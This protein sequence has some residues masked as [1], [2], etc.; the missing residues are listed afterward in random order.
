VVLAVQL[1][2]P[3][4]THAEGPVFC[5]DWGGL[6]WVDMLAGDILHLDAKTGAVERWSVGRVAAAFRPR[7]TGGMIIATER[8]FVVGDFGGPVRSVGVAFTDPA[9]RFNDG[10]CDPAGR[11][12]CG[13]MAYAG[14]PGAGSL[15]RLAG[16]DI[17][18]VIDKV[19]ISNGLEWT[20]DA[21]RVFY[22]DTPTGRVDQFDSDVGG[23]L[24]QRRPFVTIDPAAGSP[25][26][27]A[28]DSQ[29]GV[30]VA[31][32]NGGAVHHYSSSGTLEDVVEL[33]VPKVTACTFGGKNLDQLFITTSRDGENPAA[34]AVFT[35]APGVVGLPVRPFSG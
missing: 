8:E 15:Y 17:E 26:G 28:V 21:E 14:T 24:S 25:D 31:L 23:G 5:A 19:T 20:A 3:E 11:F 22:V 18:T 2:A 29:G 13:T 30:W 6:R 7:T 27:L 32:W 34:G 16:E 1:T 33:P 4:A 12:L 35:A 10:G 9:I